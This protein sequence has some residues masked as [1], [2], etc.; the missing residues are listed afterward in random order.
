MKLLTLVP[1]TTMLMKLLGNYWYYVFVSFLLYTCRGFRSF[2]VFLNYQNP[3]LFCR[4]ELVLISHCLQLY[5]EYCLLNFSLSFSSLSQYYSVPS[6]NIYFL[7]VEEIWLH[8]KW[9]GKYKSWG[10]EQLQQLLIKIDN[11][12]WK[13]MFLVLRLHRLTAFI[14]LK[15]I[16]NCFG[17][18]PLLASRLNLCHC[19]NIYFKVWL[20]YMT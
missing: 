11:K 17:C 20:N 2:P 1:D 8:Y 9:L 12:R 13:R 6:T 16:I 15:W 19:V 18:K 3:W 5:W 4:L 10:M 7:L 14:S